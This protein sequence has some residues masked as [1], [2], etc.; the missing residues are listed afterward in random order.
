MDCSK[1]RTRASLEGFFGGSGGSNNRQHIVDISVQFGSVQS[2]YPEAISGAGETGFSC[3]SAALL[4]VVGRTGL[5][6][7]SLR[8]V[9]PFVR[10]SV[11]LFS[12]S[13]SA[14][15]PAGFSREPCREPGQHHFRTELD[16]SMTHRIQ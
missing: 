10:P 13:R 2:V 9:R 11:G 6:T 14:G 3:G 16:E 7:F 8:F 5:R 12:D 4:R 1:Q 15:R